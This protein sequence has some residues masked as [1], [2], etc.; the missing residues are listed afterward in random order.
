M[1]VATNLL[2]KAGY[3]LIS[4]FGDNIFPCTV[5]KEGKPLG[6][7]HENGTVELMAQYESSR[8]EL[9]AI[10]HFAQ[11]HNGLKQ[12]PEGW[13]MLDFK[14][15]MLIADY[16][17]QKQQTVYKIYEQRNNGE[18]SLI[19]SRPSQNEAVEEF[20]RVSRLMV[21]PVSKQRQEQEQ[22]QQP[23]YV[24]QQSNREK[25]YQIVNSEGQEVGYVDRSGKATLYDQKK[26]P[27][28]P[29]FLEILRKKLS[30]IQM[31]IRVHYEKRGAHFAIRDKNQRDVAYLRPEEPTDIQ[32]TNNATPEQ[33]GKISTI[34]QD[35]LRET[36][37]IEPV[38]QPVQAEQTVPVQ[39][40]APV[41][42]PVQAEQTV[43][44]QQTVQ[45]EQTVPVQQ[46]VPEQETQEA[47]REKAAI[48][49]DFDMKMS[50]IKMMWRASIRSCP[51]SRRISSCSCMALW[52]ARHW[53]NLLIS[54]TSIC[55]IWIRILRGPD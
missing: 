50:E 23:Q 52:I 53:R 35:V 10:N 11:E 15:C 18:L 32:Y 42:Q 37:Q 28:R 9:E 51:S 40:A 1:S 54:D 16:D 48:L 41:Q 34:V 2:T 5:I 45:V 46:P 4:I 13:L 6:F 26:E 55:V 19:S 17:I 44:V 43:P 38:Q 30:D 22:N 27:T 21:S 8:A 39:Q 36:Q 3:E 7:I 29:S 20:W 33:R 14:G 24:T 31:S 25:Q 12:L 49:H 47:Q